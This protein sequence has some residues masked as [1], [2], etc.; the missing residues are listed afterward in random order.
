V[1]ARRSTGRFALLSAAFTV[2]LA[3][4]GEPRWDDPGSRFRDCASCPEMV[5]VAPG[6][7]VMGS[8]ESESGRFEDEGPRRE[9]TLA[10]PFAV[11]RTPITR[12]EFARFVQSTGR[13]LAPGCAAMSD[14]G[15]WFRDSAL[16]WSA[17]G[18]EQDGTHPV[19]CVSWDEALAFATWLSES[20]REVYRLLSEAEF[21]YVARAGSETIFAWGTDE[22]AMCA[23]ANGFD[24]AA[25]RAHPDW[26]GASCDDGYAH[27]S[28]VDAFP[29]NAFGLHDTVGNVFQWTEDCFVEG[30][31]AGAPTDGGAR[32]EEGCEL[33]AIRGGS[34]LNGPRGLR[35]AMR[36]RDRQ[37]DRYTNVGFR[38]ARAR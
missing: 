19:V 29:E 24:A 37:G 20:T 30:G 26:P 1:S 4:A 31:Y 16:T 2:A 38:L 23:R 5:V 32:I 25:R 9:V 10:A 34:W 3:C 7:F 28:P 6:S 8:P 13:N 21:E 22:T 12:A 17:P 18:F 15:R 27:T 36:D 11:S 14:A 35:A 33:R